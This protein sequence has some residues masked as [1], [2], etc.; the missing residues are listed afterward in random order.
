M[1][2]GGAEPSEF[3][4]LYSMVFNFVELDFTFYGILDANC[5]AQLSVCLGVISHDIVIEHLQANFMDHVI[6][7]FRPDDLA[8]DSLEA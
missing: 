6:C 1:A 3:L 4:K 8:H 7:S 5:V 2:L